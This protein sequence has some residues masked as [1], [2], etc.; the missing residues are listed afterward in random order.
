MAQVLLRQTLC[1]HPHI[2]SLNFFTLDMLC[3]S[4]Y[5]NIS[6]SL[7]SNTNCFT[8]SDIIIV[9]Y[10]SLKPLSVW[11]SEKSVYV[12]GFQFKITCF[13]VNYR[14]FP[15]TYIPPPQTDNIVTTMN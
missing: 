10:G 4:L 1:C 5:K 9:P 3:V 7:I 13:V 8:E 6:L 2:L 11:T 14:L 15:T 12:C